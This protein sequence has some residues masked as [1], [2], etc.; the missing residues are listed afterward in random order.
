MAFN[1]FVC[2]VDIKC[3]GWFVRTL[4]GV[5]FEPFRVGI[6]VRLKNLIY[7]LLSGALQG[8]PLHKLIIYGHLLAFL[9]VV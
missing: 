1:E 2:P 6:L 8:L 7:L 5:E 4:L 9:Y 3:C